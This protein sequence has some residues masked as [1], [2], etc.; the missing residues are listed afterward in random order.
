MRKKKQKELLEA[1]D[2]RLE[3][4][5]EE[6]ESFG[7]L[8]RRMLRENRLAVLSALVILLFVLA[9]IF[10]SLLTPYSFDEMDLMNRLSPPSKIHLLGTD[11][12]G[13]DILL[14]EGVDP[15][16]FLATQGH[17]VVRIA[18]GGRSYM[19]YILDDSDEKYRVKSIF[20]PYSSK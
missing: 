20:G 8:M 17:V 9:A 11:D 18:P 10:A 5:I 19:I 2:L 14:K 6:E 15:S 4:Q 3:S 12:G 13:R 1:H 7:T 16:T